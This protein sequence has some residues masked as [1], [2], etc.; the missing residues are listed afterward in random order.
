MKL[1]FGKSVFLLRAWHAPGRTV[2]KK[3][4]GVVFPGSYSKRIS[5]CSLIQAVN[6]KIVSGIKDP[7]LQ[8]GVCEDTSH[9]E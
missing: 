8:M 3:W 6:I 4:A 9:G 2:I 5:A 1:G 7:N